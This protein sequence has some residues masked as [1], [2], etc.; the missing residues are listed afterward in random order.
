MKTTKNIGISGVDSIRIGEMKICD[1]PIAESAIAA[2]QIPLSEDVERQNKIADVLRGYPT[3]KVGYL[4]SR[5]HES[6]LNIV[7]IGEMKSQQSVLISEYTAQITLCQ[8]RDKQIALID[9]LDVD[10]DAK[11]KQLFKDFPPYQVDAMTQQIIQS[12][13]SI[14]RADSVIASEY[15]SIAEMRELKGLCEQR[16]TVLRNLNAQVAS[17]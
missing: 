17:A 7:K 10:K 8:F 9:D 16:D 13:E 4:T 11:I 6:E 14:E 15:N 5:M 2:Q 1:L 3:H 12:K